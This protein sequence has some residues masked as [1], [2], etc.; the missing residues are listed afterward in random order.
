M[1]I[2]KKEPI[3]TASVMAPPD[4]R[5]SQLVNNEITRLGSDISHGLTAL[6]AG[7]ASREQNKNRAA[8]IAAKEAEAE[9]A[10]ERARM[11]A[12]DKSLA[13]AR[14]EQMD[15]RYHADKATLD[16]Y[17]G[18]LI[19][20]LNTDLAKANTPEELK[21]IQSQYDSKLDAIPSTKLE[22]G[23]ALV[24]TERLQRELGAEIPGFKKAVHTVISK[25]GLDLD[26]ARTAAA[27][28]Q[29]IHAGE[30]TFDQNAIAHG[31]AI[32]YN[33]GLLTEEEANEAQQAS[34]ERAAAANVTRDLG[35][36]T[37]TDL[38]IHAQ[39]Q[40]VPES[41]LADEEY[42]TIVQGTI[43]TLKKQVDSDYP[44]LPEEDQAQIKEKLTKQLPVALNKMTAAKKTLVDYK[45]GLRTEKVQ[46]AIGTLVE[47]GP[48]ASPIEAG[49]AL[50]A[51]A[52]DLYSP[53][54]LSSAASSWNQQDASPAAYNS[55]LA[56]RGRILAYNPNQDPGRKTY[57][58]LFTEAFKSG[59][60]ANEAI[61]ELNEAEGNL[62][63]G[64]M[65]AS[66]HQA[67]RSKIYQVTERSKLLS[68]GS[69]F[70]YISLGM[71]PGRSVPM[72][73]A[74]IKVMQSVEAAA[75]QYN[76]TYDQALD[77]LNKSPIF[78]RIETYN[79]QRE[80]EDALDSFTGNVL[81]P[82]REPVEEQPNPYTT[83]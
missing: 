69:T 47:Q 1:P 29:L 71:G 46:A 82:Y 75:K 81:D 42:A 7:L 44:F 77:Y 40:G 27:A 16:L 35:F 10:K 22:N 79:S 45:N 5:G 52:G 70:Q 74:Q 2:I 63:F 66:E 17:A 83:P 80:Y 24:R 55:Y 60:W 61:A 57:S 30:A 58:K 64:G 26:R 13:A 23:S 39:I 54:R 8:A 65:S 72:T 19:N 6:G 73:E 48:I 53:Q 9:A 4:T 78:Q 56:L 68:K 12:A 59:Y 38:S 67:L 21:K 37:S 51:V 43:N 33:A 41:E 50:D 28:D 3:S 15:A 49:E 34:L 18:D 76:F 14:K 25:R 31:I 20:Q 62:P 11:Q 32:K 36:I